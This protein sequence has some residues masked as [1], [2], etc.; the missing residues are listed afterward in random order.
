MHETEGGV[1]T[2]KSWRDLLAVRVVCYECDAG[3]IA[4]GET[5][6]DIKQPVIGVALLC[7]FSLHWFVAYRDNMRLVSDDVDMFVRAV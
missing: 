6:V 3:R 1:K 7:V 5:D 2:A 4:S